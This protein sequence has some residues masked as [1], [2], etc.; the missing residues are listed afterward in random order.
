ML[1]QI[2]GPIFPICQPRIMIKRWRIED[3]GSEVKHGEA[4]DRLPNPK[5]SIL[6]PAAHFCLPARIVHPHTAHTL[7]LSSISVRYSSPHSLSEVAHPQLGRT[8]QLLASSLSC[9]PRPH[10]GDAPGI[11]SCTCSS[12]SESPTCP[13]DYFSSAVREK[14]HISF[15]PTFV[16]PVGGQYLSSIQPYPR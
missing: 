12:H 10:T 9:C 1:A 11:Q 15:W 16:F 6:P 2:V 5:L 7:P 13:P 14:K 8:Q 4:T 3:Q